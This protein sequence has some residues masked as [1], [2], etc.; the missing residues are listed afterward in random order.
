MFFGN[1]LALIEID[2]TV[3]SKMD[4]YPLFLASKEAMSP[5]WA[6]TATMGTH[7]LIFVNGEFCKDSRP[8]NYFL[9]KKENLGIIGTKI[10]KT[11]IKVF[12]LWAVAVNV[13]IC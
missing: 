12:M 11:K 1:N 5:S 7:A 4:L 3:H 13:T 6:I 10:T 9:N 8:E 2:V